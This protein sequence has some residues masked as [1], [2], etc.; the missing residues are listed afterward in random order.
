MFHEILLY[1]IIIQSHYAGKFKILPKSLHRLN[2][3]GILKEGVCVCERERDKERERE[4]QTDRE[5]VSER[6][7]KKERDE[8]I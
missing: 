5:R 1:I 2:L 4:R 7:R 8:Y 3:F 6:E